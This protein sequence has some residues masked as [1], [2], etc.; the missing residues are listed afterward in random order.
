MI[1]EIMNNCAPSYLSEMLEN[2]FGST[3]Y[4]L[5]SYEIK[6]SDT[7][8]ANRMLQTKFCRVW[9]NSLEIIAKISEGGGKFAKI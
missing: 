3:N 7:K 4:N 6:H 8:G 5:R 2:Q 1:H 9:P